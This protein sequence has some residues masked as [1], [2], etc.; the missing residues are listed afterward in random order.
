MTRMIK[1]ITKT[2]S[3]IR[4]W[5]RRQALF[6]LFSLA[7]KRLLNSVCPSVG[8]SV[9]PSVIWSRFRV[10]GLVVM[11]TPFLN[12]AS[13]LLFAF[14]MEALMGI[15]SSHTCDASSLILHDLL[16]VFHFDESVLEQPTH[17]RTDRL[18]DL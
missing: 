17:G 18:S 5:K 4:A 7:T 16:H 13:S 14:L 15:A 6:I 10:S 8:L 1:T 9:R 3:P 12:V 11:G 2:T